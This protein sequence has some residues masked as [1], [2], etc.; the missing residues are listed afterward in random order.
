[1]DRRGNMNENFREIAE[2]GVINIGNTARF[3]EKFRKLEKGEP[4]TI[5]FL[6]GSITQG[7]VA[8]DSTKCYAYNVYSWFKEKFPKSD[9]TYINAGIGAT[10]SRYGVARAVR[11]VL[12]KKPD[13]VSIEFAVNDVNEDFCQETFEGCVRKILNSESKP[14]LY[15]FDN[16]MYDTGYSAEEKHNAVGM[17]YSIPICSMKSTLYAEVLKG[18]LKRED[19]TP[20]NLHPNDYGHRMVADVIINLLEHVYEQCHA[21]EMSYLVP[22]VPLTKNRFENACVFNNDNVAYEG[23]FDKELPKISEIQAE[24]MTVK[25]HVPGSVNVRLSGFER[26]THKP[27]GDWDRHFTKGFT[28]TQKDAYIQFEFE[29]SQVGVLWR[30]T[31]NKPAPVAEAEIIDVDGFK[32]VKLDANFE[33]TWGD[34]LELTKVAEDLPAGKHTMRIRIVDMPEDSKSDF[35]I[36]GITLA[37]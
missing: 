14:A 24:S 29:A 31:I 8:S 11:D 9:I 13:I 5:A 23:S 10:D 21:N 32:P 12:S 22:S 4:V 1:M 28:T 27:A 7:S 16:V 37:K 20:D 3:G 2:R 36:A 19:F 25:E 30:R 33:E 18:N 26:D 34:K 6:G 15:M 35:Y 17:Y